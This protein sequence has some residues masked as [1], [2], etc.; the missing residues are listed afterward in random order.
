MI[1]NYNCVKREITTVVTKVMNTIYFTFKVFMV[2]AAAFYNKHKKQISKGL[3]NS[4]VS[5]F[6]IIH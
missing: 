2:T 5:K 6:W 1:T 3:N 4:P